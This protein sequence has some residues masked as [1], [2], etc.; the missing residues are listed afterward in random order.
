MVGKNIILIGM[1][2]LWFSGCSI[3]TIGHGE[4]YCEER[5]ADYADAGVCDDPWTIYKNR[6]ELSKLKHSRCRANKKDRWR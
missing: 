3:M 6:H 1:T 4:T 5:G 2:A